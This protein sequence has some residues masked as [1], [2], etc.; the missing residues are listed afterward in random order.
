M[1]LNKLSPFPW[2]SGR[3]RTYLALAD[4]QHWSA[5]ADLRLEMLDVVE[6]AIIAE[7]SKARTEKPKRGKAEIPVSA[8]NHIDWSRFARPA[9]RVLWLSSHDED[10]ILAYDSADA[11]EAEISRWQ[12]ENMPDADLIDAVRRAVKIRSEHKKAMTIPR[13]GKTS[14]DSGN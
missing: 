9:A 3:E 12:R 4:I 7:L 1:N 14:G 11:L 8:N 6:P 5:S 2:S 10:V 13:P